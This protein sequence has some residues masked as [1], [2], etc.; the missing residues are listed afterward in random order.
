MYFQYP[1]TFFSVGC[2]ENCHVALCKWTKTE[3]NKDFLFQWLEQM[4]LFPTS[5]LLS[6]WAVSNQSLRLFFPMATMGG[7]RSLRSGYFSLTIDHRVLVFRIITKRGSVG[8]LV[9]IRS[10]TAI[11]APPFPSLAWESA[12]GTP[13]ACRAGKRPKTRRHDNLLLTE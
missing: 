3:V 2:L 4:Y 7:K 6:R 13:A 12:L 8:K 11:K 10:T 1:R 5:F 9:H